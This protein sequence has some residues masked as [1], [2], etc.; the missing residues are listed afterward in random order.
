M[1]RVVLT[2]SVGKG[3]KN[4]AADVAV[5]RQRLRDL[6]YDWVASTGAG[7]EAGLVR[8]IELFQAICA[9]KTKFESGGAVN[10]KVTKGG[11][12]HKWLAAKNA[13]GWLKIY[14]SHG[15]GWSTTVHPHIQSTGSPYT[16]KNGGY[17]TTW[18]LDMIKNAALQYTQTWKATY[19]LMWIRDV[20]GQKGGNVKY[21]GS[22][23]TGLDVDLRLPLKPVAGI[24]PDAT[25]TFL[26][27]RAQR[28]RHLY[29]EAVEDQLRALVAQPLVEVIGYEDDTA[30]KGQRK[31]HTKWG[32]VRPWSNHKHHMHVRIKPPAMDA[33]QIV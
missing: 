22:H 31:L 5:V 27:T 1:A 3:C 24:F 28:K 6:G 30:P 14:G 18:V 26:E 33:G 2:S 20:A 8:T 12:T 13:P 25:W 7:D 10:G 23:E 15:K 21:H 32:K 11:S 17:G 16:E 29:R 19:P 9:G 4:E